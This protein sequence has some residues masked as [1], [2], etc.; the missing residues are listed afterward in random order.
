MT[1]NLNDW[2]LTAHD[3]DYDIQDNEFWTFRCGEINLIAT[4]D[5]D[6][7]DRWKI[8]TKF[9]R[10]NNRFFDSKD[11]RIKFFAMIFHL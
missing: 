5:E 6:M 9:C 1:L 3:A 2:D 7:F 4:A 10:E 11:N 8:A